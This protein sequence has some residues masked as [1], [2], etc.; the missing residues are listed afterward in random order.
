M[1][2]IRVQGKAYVDYEVEVEMNEEDSHDFEAGYL[3]YD[4]IQSRYEKEIEKAHQEVDLNE[5]DCTFETIGVLE[6]DKE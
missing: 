6:I 5:W 4:D 1:Y 3:T 2:V